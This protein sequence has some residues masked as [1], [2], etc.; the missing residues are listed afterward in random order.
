[1]AKLKRVVLLMPM[2]AGHGAVDLQVLLH[3]QPVRLV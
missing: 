3:Q 2:A 1:M